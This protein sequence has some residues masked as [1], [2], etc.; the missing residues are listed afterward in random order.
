MTSPA[1]PNT[2]QVSQALN[3]LIYLRHFE[4]VAFKSG[5]S[6]NKLLHCKANT[7][8]QCQKIPTS[9]NYSR[10]ELVR[11]DPLGVCL[12]VLYSRHLWFLALLLFNS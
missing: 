2:R 8:T 10:Y 12:L 1:P 7:N 4:R 6:I 9:Q 11:I 5:F 3:L